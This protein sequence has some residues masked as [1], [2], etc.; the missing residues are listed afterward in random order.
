MTNIERMQASI[1][2]FF[3]YVNILD[4]SWKN[5]LC[6]VCIKTILELYRVYCKVYK[7]ISVVK[8]RGDFD[9]L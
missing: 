9:Y 6:N 5:L 3:E 1:P 8:M 4:K 2:I 7:N